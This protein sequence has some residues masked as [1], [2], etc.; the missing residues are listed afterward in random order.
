MR[1][2][3]LVS[4]VAIAAAQPAPKFEVASVKLDASPAGRGNPLFEPQRLTWRGATLKRMIC[5]AYQVQYAQ[6]AGAP[7]WSDTERY[8]VE[9][10]AEKPAT[11]AELR[12]MLKSLL[13]DR[14]RLTV[15]TATKPLPVYVLTVA[16]GGPKLREISPDEQNTPAQPAAINRFSRRASM[17]QFA[18]LLSQMISGPV[19]NGYTGRMEPRDDEPVMVVDRTGLK[20]VYEIHLDLNGTVD[21]DSHSTLVTAVAALGLKLGLER[22]PVPIVTVTGVQRT[23]SAN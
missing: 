1:L 8:V 14:F 13:A 18:S 15:R 11:T 21:G 22:M 23:P 10:R 16:N 6:V 12:E 19:F 3:L 20:G 2:A 7:A 5:E 9:A 4:V 17:P